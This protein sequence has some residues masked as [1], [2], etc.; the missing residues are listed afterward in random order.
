MRVCVN[1]EKMSGTLALSFLNFTSS[2]S[3]ALFSNHLHRLNNAPCLRPLPLPQTTD[4]LM[5]CFGGV[6]P[7]KSYLSTPDKM[8]NL[9]S[10]LQ[11]VTST[12][13]PQRRS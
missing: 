9:L 5:V 3:T 4:P 2:F 11:G 7:V 6:W 1:A 8:G 10:P 12:S 13:N